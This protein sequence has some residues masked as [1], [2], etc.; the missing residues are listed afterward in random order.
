MLEAL[1][2]LRQRVLQVLVLFLVVFALFFSQ[3]SELVTFI[4]KPLLFALPIPGKLIATQVTSGVLSPLKLSFQMALLALSPLVLF[5]LWRFAAPG[6]YR[7][8]NYRLF[9]ILLVSF[10]LF[11]CGLLFCFYAVLPFLF[12]WIVK[13]IPQDVILMP[14]LSATLA[15][16]AQMLFVFGLC[17]QLP[18][19]CFML[20]RL[21]WVNLKQLQQGRPYAIVLAFILG[22]L[23]TPPDVLS[24][25][26]VALPLCFLYEFGIILVKITSFLQVRSIKRQ[27]Q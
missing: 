20:V 8:E 11:V 7:N 3:S 25:I 16:I 6:L 9:S 24:Q 18:L 1:I 27:S 19:I 23:L 17:F 10:L 14:D 12:Q 22:M 4:V 15:F 21:Q 5:H 2:E 13:A 26:L